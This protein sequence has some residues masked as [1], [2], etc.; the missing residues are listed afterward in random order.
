MLKKEEYT[1]LYSITRGKTD[2]EKL[3]N[4]FND[5]QKLRK[6]IIELENK[7]LISIE[8]R[9]GEIYG[10]IETEKGETELNNKKYIEWFNE[11]GD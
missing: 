9:D 10:F 2:L 1:V 6:I 7:K 4:V 11:L 5:D 8:L 3:K